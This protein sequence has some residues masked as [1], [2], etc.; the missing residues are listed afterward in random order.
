MRDLGVESKHQFKHQFIRQEVPK[1][2][3]QFTCIPTT[4]PAADGLTEPL[5]SDWG[6]REKISGHGLMSPG[7]VPPSLT[8]PKQSVG[9]GN[10][11]S[12]R[13]SA[14]WEWYITRLC[15]SMVLYLNTRSTAIHSSKPG[16][17]V[18]R[19]ARAALLL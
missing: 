1:S 18:Q 16:D 10:S 9:A 14:C 12:A 8:G 7:T 4:N 5:E 3:V 11:A 2:N 13:S 6:A 17:E 19:L 15:F